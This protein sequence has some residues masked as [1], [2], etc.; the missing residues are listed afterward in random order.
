MALLP[1]RSL[2]FEATVRK[3]TMPLK[4]SPEDASDDGG[5]QNHWQKRKLGCNRSQEVLHRR[6]NGDHIDR[7]FGGLQRQGS[8]RLHL[9]LDPDHEPSRMLRRR[10]PLREPVCEGCHNTGRARVIATPVG[11][12]WCGMGKECGFSL[13]GDLNRIDG[14]SGVLR[15]RTCI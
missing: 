11:W 7:R 15:V 3:S 9:L 4:D 13:P 10:R 8:R 14:S 1:L 2:A 5:S 12:Q 6:R